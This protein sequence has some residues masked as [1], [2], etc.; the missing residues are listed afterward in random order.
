M[1][2]AAVRVDASEH[3]HP[4]ESG[5]VAAARDVAFAH[6]FAV[7]FVVM[8]SGFDADANAVACQPDADVRRF[9]DAD[10]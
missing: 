8:I 2:F 10:C 3:H 6:R 7:G 1:F 9:A 4:G 5:V